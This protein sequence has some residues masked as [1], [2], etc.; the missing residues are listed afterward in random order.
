MRYRDRWTAA[1]RIVQERTRNGVGDT[2]QPRLLFSGDG[3][4][5]PIFRRGEMPRPGD[6]CALTI[7]FS[8]KRGSLATVPPGFEP[9]RDLLLVH[10]ARHDGVGVVAACDGQQS[11]VLLEPAVVGVEVSTKIRLSTEC[12]DARQVSRCERGCEKEHR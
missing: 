11:I 2:A 8:G 5:G 9:Q 4:P 7:E 10:V 6:R 12:P 3:L 1:A